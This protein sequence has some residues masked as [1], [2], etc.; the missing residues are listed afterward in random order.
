[1]TGESLRNDLSGVTGVSGIDTLKELAAQVALAGSCLLVLTHANESLSRSSWPCI[2]CW[3]IL[4][5]YVTI[6]TARNT[7]S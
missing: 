5:N 4:L 3:W 7:R 1:M 6:C 2:C